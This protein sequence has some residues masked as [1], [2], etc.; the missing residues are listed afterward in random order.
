MK[1]AVKRTWPDKPKSWELQG[2]A[3]SAEAFALDFAT[4]QGLGMG[5]ELVV[6]EKEGDDSEIQF[7]K[8]ANASPYQLVPAEPR[9]GGPAPPAAQDPAALPSTPSSA[10]VPEVGSLAV[11]SVR[12]FVSMIFYM[13]KVGV[14]AMAIIYGLAMLFRYIRSA[15]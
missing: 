1:Y 15:L 8:V 10:D 3:A 5:T 2:E 13:V 11:P 4:S 9:A 7:F 6:I 14:I 12:P